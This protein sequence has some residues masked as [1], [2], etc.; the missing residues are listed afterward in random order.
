MTDYDHGTYIKWYYREKANK[1]Q[2]DFY[3][4]QMLKLSGEWVAVDFQSKS[5][6][7]FFIQVCN[8]HNRTTNEQVILDCNLDCILL[9][10]SMCRITQ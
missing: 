1:S 6:Q 3:V 4:N 8:L 2:K 7:F 9:C 10:E 5:V